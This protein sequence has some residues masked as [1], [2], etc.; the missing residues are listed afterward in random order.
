[1]AV[2]LDRALSEEV[3]FYPM[4]IFKYSARIKNLPPGSLAFFTLVSS[5]GL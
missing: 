2:F 5:L 3:T 1:M 4:T